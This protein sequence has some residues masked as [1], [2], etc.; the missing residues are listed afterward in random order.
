M[1]ILHYSKSKE[2]NMQDGLNVQ[3]LTD[4]AR[5]FIDKT[6]KQYPNEVKKFLRSEGN[7]LKNHVKAKAKGKFKKKTGNYMKGF[8]RGKPYKYNSD[9]DAIR[10]YNSMPHAHLLEKGHRIVDKYKNEHGFKQGVNVVDSTSGEFK[11]E[12]A[13]DIENWV[14]DMLNKG[15]D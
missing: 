12:F 10:V 6:S 14:D 8:K 13:R 11:D 3:E 7:K 4:F 2:D 9:E 1:Y 15:I 5:N